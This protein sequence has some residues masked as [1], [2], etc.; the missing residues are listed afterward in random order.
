MESQD[1]L[2]EA[3]DTLNERKRKDPDCLTK[4]E[5]ARWR[6]LRCEIEEALFQI[7]R[8]PGTD[9][10]E[11]L[12]VPIYMKV[13]YSVAGQ[14]QERYLTILGE[15]G[16]FV[17]TNDFQPLGTRLNF[18]GFPVSGGLPFKARGEVVWV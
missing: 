4:T 7:T 11:F 1:R 18:Q 9:T 12:R 16:L 14:I 10:R 5:K 17:A 3:F 13:A 6:M 2:I 8:D 15:G